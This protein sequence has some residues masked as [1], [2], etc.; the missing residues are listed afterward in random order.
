MLTSFE[1]NHNDG[2]REVTYGS[3]Y[4]VFLMARGCGGDENRRVVTAS[5][6]AARYFCDFEG[7]VQYSG[8]EGCAKIIQP[9]GHCISIKSALI[10]SIVL[11]RCCECPRGIVADGVMRGARGWRAALTIEP[12]ILACLAV[13]L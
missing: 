5:V 3:A 9:W 12:L 1:V 8:G 4:F 7:E 10:T 2:G 6:R 11:P 13:P